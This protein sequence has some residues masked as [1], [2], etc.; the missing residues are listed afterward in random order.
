M[1][2]ITGL[3]AG[4]LL[5]ATTTCAQ[6][7]WTGSIYDN[8]TDSMVSGVMGLDWSSSGSGLATG[9]GPAGTPLTTGT[10]FDFLYQASLVG[11]T[12]PTGQ[13]VSLPGLSTAFEYT[14][15]AKIPET[16]LFPA[17]NIPG[18]NI[19]ATTSG[20]TFAIYNQAAPN[21]NVAAGTG[22]ND[23]TLV[24]SG[25]INAN[26]ISTFT[27]TGAGGIGIGSTVLEGLVLFVDPLFFN[28]ASFIMDFRFEGTLN[29]PPLDSA[30][31]NFFDGNDGF[32][33][34]PVTANDINFKVDGSSK[35]STVPEPS[36]M[37]LLGVGLMGVAG[38]TRKR[39]QK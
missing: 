12:G 23:G 4:L 29:Y 37:L 24:A 31:V 28:P 6:A 18:T 2:K 35:F 34:T 39:M 8:A 19:F 5:I 17:T 11:V 16:V 7:F 33:V 32:A 9:L 27:V 25:T 36:T 10:T 14:V 21:S 13:P 15:V 38:L 26:Q 30:T 1:K 22:F 20:G 3:I